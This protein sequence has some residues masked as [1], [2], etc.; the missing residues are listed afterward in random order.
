VHAAGGLNVEDE[1]RG[2]AGFV[3]RL[4]FAHSEVRATEHYLELPGVIQVRGRRFVPTALSRARCNRCLP[5]RGHSEGMQ[6]PPL[7]AATA[8]CHR[9]PS[10]CHGEP[11]N[12]GF[13]SVICEPWTEGERRS[14]GILLQPLEHLLQLCFAHKQISIAG[15]A[16][17][18]E[19]SQRPRLDLT[20][21]VMA[22][23]PRLVGG[24]LRRS[25]C[26][27]QSV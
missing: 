4:S 7:G 18:H 25:S 10:V 24:N 22:R 2:H 19:K 5:Y 15:P 13:R 8:G 17:P 14:S 6:W 16:L 9:E 3:L 11:N 12:R 21:T 27:N 20:R 26:L 23:W 1:V